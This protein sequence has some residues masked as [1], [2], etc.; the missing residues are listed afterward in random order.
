MRDCRR[1]S[2]AGFADASGWAATSQR[3]SAGRARY[4]RARR[5]GAWVT[6]CWHCSAKAPKS[7]CARPSLASRRSSPRTSRSMPP[8]RRALHAGRDARATR[9]REFCSLVIARALAFEDALRIVN[10]RGKAMQAAA[11]A[12]RAAGCRRFSGW[13][14]QQVRDVLGALQSRTRARRAGQ[15]QLADA[16]RHQRRARRACKRAATAMLAAGAK[17]VVPLNVSGAWHSEL[18]QPAVER[19]A[20]AVDAA[21]FAMPAFDVIS[22]VDARP[23]RDVATIKAQS[24]AF[25]RRRSALARDGAATALGYGLDRSSSSAP[26][27]VLGALMKRMPSAAA[28][29]RRERS[30][31]RREAAQRDRRAGGGE[32]Y[33]IQRE[34]RARHRRK[35][36]HRPRHRGRVCRR[37]GRRRA[38]RTRPRGVAKRRAAAVREA[39]ARAPLQ[40]F[41]PATSPIERRWNESSP[42]SSS[43][44]G[45]SIVRSPTPANRSTRF[46]C[47]SSP[48]RSTVCST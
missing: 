5:D 10:E 33:E 26:S 44:S 18:M 40:R 46:C 38:G 6:I 42:R 4:L 2:G 1:L 30:V 9:L 8:S 45:A 36:R 23:Y 35:P 27:G 29:E 13:R 19:F 7:D 17:R 16:D 25:G 41:S 34:R 21:Q 39:R 28:G 11:A 24:G 43:A 14:R 31:G 48:R 20:A 32:A 37:R 47:D 15:L 22:N 12:L 3:D